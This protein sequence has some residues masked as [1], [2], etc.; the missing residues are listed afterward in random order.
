MMNE[1]VMKQTKKQMEQ[2]AEPMRKLQGK[3][4][5]HTQKMAEY[6]LDLART[7]TDL[8]FGQIRELVGIGTPEELQ[9]YVQRSSETA[10]RTGE[11]MTK[12]AQALAEMGKSMGD[13]VQQW[14]QENV[15]EITGRLNVAGKGP[16]KAA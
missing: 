13:D 3:M 12:D 9:G 14:V 10:R 2:A 4:L 8:A 15:S 1:D 7:Y 6:Q 11:Q 5:E 16:R